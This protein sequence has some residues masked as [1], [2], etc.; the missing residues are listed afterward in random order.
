MRLTENTMEHAER[1][2]IL[3]IMRADRRPI[4]TACLIYVLIGLMAVSIAFTSLPAPLASAETLEERR[5]RLESELAALESEIRELSVFKVEKSRE[6]VSLERDIAILEAQINEAQLSIRRRDLILNQI[7]GDITDKTQTIVDLNLKVKREQSSLAQLIRRTREVDDVSLVE[8]VLSGSSLSE[9]FSD[10]DNFAE[11][12]QALGVSFKEIAMLKDD[13][14]AR[15][16]VLESKHKEESDLRQLQVLERQAIERRENEK[17]DILDVT[18]G[19]EQAYQ[20]MITERE[21]NAAEIRSALFSLRDSSAIKF[22]DAYRYATDASAKTGVRPALILAILAEESN[23]GENVGTGNWRDDMHPTRDAPVFEELMRELGLDPDQMPVS[24]K[25]WYGWGGA[26]GPAQFIPSTWILYKDR[27][28][29]MTGENP[30]NPWTPRT[31][32]FA[33]AILMEDNG[34]DKGT[35]DAERLAALRYFAGWTNATKSAYAFYGDD[36]MRL[37]DKFQAQVDILEG[38]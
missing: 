38:R 20:K 31:A 2:G 24:K 1:N 25:P 7:Q 18:A 37:A 13:L 21:K 14:S 30:P 32:I 22:G 12:Q 28:A 23:L 16:E 9:M 10:I 17:K 27:I 15:K 11:I 36:V 35:R 6:R 34:A 29:Q 33:S 5:A 4:L 3:H 19:Q 26:M 8:L